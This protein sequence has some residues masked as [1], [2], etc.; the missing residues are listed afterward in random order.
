MESDTRWYAL[1][2]FALVLLAIIIPRYLQFRSYSDRGAF[3]VCESIYGEIKSLK[4]GSD[5][6]AGWANLEGQA[7]P[8]LEEVTVDIE[9]H[10]GGKTSASSAIYQLAKYELPRAIEHR[11]R[12]AGKKLDE[13]FANALQLIDAPYESSVHDVKNRRDGETPE[14]WDPVVMGI[15]AIDGILFVSGVAYVLLPRRRT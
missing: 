10:L 4:A 14:S 13:D 5:D 6:Q 9:A 8:K 15:L 2:A 1:G 12:T 11:G 7:I 3:E